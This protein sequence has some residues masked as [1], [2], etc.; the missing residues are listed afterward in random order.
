MEA[1]LKQDTPIRSP[2]RRWRWGLALGVGLAV[3]VPVAWA[4]A[5][6]GG[7]LVRTKPPLARMVGNPLPVIVAAVTREQL[8]EVVGGTTLVQPLMS[9]SVN[10]AV[11]DGLVRTVRAE[12]GELVLRGDVLVE[13]DTD[14]FRQA[15]GRARQGVETA[16]S[17]QGRIEAEAATR[18][19]ELRAAVAMGKEQVA[20]AQTIASALETSYGR[21][22]T[23]LGREL[24]AIAAVDEARVKWEQAKSTLA[25]ARLEL[26]RAENELANE[27]AVTRALVES[28][29]LKLDQ[30][31]HELA[32]ARRNMDNT[33]VRSPSAGMLSQRSVNPG[34]WV[35]SGKSLF[36]LDLIE[37]VFAVAEIEQEKAPYLALGQDAEVV[38]DAHP[39]QVFRGPVA[40]IEPSIDPA[41]RTFKTFVRLANS[42]LALRP[43]MAG[44]T[45]VTRR[46][47]VTL[48]PRLAAINPTGA[49]TLDATLFVIEGDR[50]VPRKVKLG[51]AEGIGRVEVL[52]GVKPGELV[53]V[54]GHKEL[55]P[56]DRVAA[57]VLDGSGALPG[58][59]PAPESR[60]D[61]A[62]S[63]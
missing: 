10:V 24:V 40:R 52:G 21:F 63:R 45:R 61:R 16:R 36:R 6:A 8:T 2:R 23:L 59:D 29:R 43:G 49:P 62:A 1:N 26:V 56:G 57:R 30:A 5:R 41:K 33:V 9:V 22:T 58:A 54:H 7:M 38:F 35:A 48:M 32:K 50:A 46:R 4:S 12:V 19:R 20:A 17:D 44:F 3:L 25:T 28:A 27:P 34:E 47:E 37:T 14:V 55:N 15:L 18:G 51:R 31:E 53:V 42:A 60:K 11:S 39:T 13:F